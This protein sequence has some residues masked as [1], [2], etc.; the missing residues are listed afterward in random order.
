MEKQVL[1]IG[2][3]RSGVA[4][5]KLLQRHHYLV[6]LTDMN[7]VMEKKELE[8]L[9]IQVFDQGH[10]EHLK[11]TNYEF[12]VKNPGIKYTVPFVHYFV[13]QGI[14]I[15]TEV[16]IGYRYAKKFNYGA[17]TGTNG[18]TTITTMLYDMLNYNHKAMVAGNIGIPLSELAYEYE[19]EEKDIALEL[20]N[21]QLLGIKNFHPSVSVVCNLAPDH[22]DYMPSVE[23][24]YE[25]K[26]RIYENCCDTDWFLR[27]V[28][29][30]LVMKYAQKVPC[31]II[32]FSL[33][34][35]DVA[36]HRSQGSVY[37]KDM[38]LFEEIDLHIVGEYNLSNAM[39]ASCMAFK[40]G[41][42]VEDI[43]AAIK[44]L[45]PVEHRL[46]YIGEKLGVKFY[47]DS[48][49]TNTHAVVA[50]L[51]SFQKNIILIA[52]GYDKGISF[53]DLRVFDERVKCCIAFGETKQQFAP[54]FTNAIL[55]E[56]MKEALD[57]AIFM[58]SE[59]DVVIL[60]P[61][62]SSYDQ[63]PNYEVRGTLFKEM[64]HAY[65]GT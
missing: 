15:L 14:Q 41:V 16:E 3:A 9:G 52:G 40:L 48:K 4:V 13:E 54:I 56:T 62:C 22:L 5:S 2:G 50:A 10:P 47:N 37:L 42:R 26:M 12:V 24:Y 23:S 44:L 57:E 17:I 53:D 27:N 36:L 30:A 55:K 63:F 20:S 61:A 51:Q 43:R 49:A 46:E 7:E 60:S 38:K 34:R 58:A 29:D 33:V 1:V 59:G 45:K 28:D 39:V 19:A 18:K 35:D 8:A 65:F 6:M 31:E 21:F 25:S 64:V 11:H 32:D